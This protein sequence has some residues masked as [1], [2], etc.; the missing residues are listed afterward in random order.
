MESVQDMLRRF[1]SLNVED[2]QLK[3]SLKSI[4]F[5]FDRRVSSM[6]AR[7]SYYLPTGKTC[8]RFREALTFFFF[9]PNG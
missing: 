7:S 5:V 9:F 3:S 2:E 8:N 4:H 1:F 6:I